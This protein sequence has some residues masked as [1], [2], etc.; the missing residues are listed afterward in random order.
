MHCIPSKCIPCVVVAVLY[1]WNCLLSWYRSPLKVHSYRASTGNVTCIYGGRPCGTW[2]WIWWTCWWNAPLYNL[3]WRVMLT[4]PFAEWPKNGSIWLL[5]NIFCANRFVFLVLTLE[6]SLCT[7]STCIASEYWWFYIGG[8]ILSDQIFYR[9]KVK[10]FLCKRKAIGG[11][12][13]MVQ[14]MNS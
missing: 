2:W 14:L 10:C 3:H 4:L 5:K 13:G 11:W 9:K 12:G 8:Q 6:D 7:Y 1:S